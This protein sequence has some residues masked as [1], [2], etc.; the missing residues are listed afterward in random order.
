MWGCRFG[1]MGGPTA[2]N[3]DSSEDANDTCAINLM[4]QGQRREV[5]TSDVS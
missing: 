3:T 4:A 2:R 1:G 5:A